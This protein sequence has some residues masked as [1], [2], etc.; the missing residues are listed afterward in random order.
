MKNNR[1][2]TAAAGNGA[3]PINVFRRMLEEKRQELVAA[4]GVKFDSI[5]K[6]GRVAEEDQAQ[7]SHDEYI[8]LT[9]NKQD[10]QVLK[11][12]DEAL[13]RIAAGDYGVCQRCEEQISPRRLEVLPWAKYCVKCQDRIA[14]RT[15]EE[16]DAS[17]L[18]GSW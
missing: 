3:L 5:A 11:L 16:D 6:A 13:D 2:Q 14:A 10:Y 4:L 18:A 12:V 15:Y 9:R 17:V 1:V 8:S 7:M